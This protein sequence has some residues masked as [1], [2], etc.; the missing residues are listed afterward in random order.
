MTAL[1]DPAT[2]APLVDVARAM[3]D[4][5]IA[6]DIPAQATNPLQSKVGWFGLSNLAAGLPGLPLG[7]L[8]IWGASLIGRAP[9]RDLQA[10]VMESHTPRGHPVLPQRD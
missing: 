10:S 3:A 2:G 7:F 8:V 5:K 6:A 4:A 1:A 9:P